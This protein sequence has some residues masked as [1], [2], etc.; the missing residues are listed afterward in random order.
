MTTVLNRKYVPGIGP[1]SGRASLMIV[2]EAPGEV[3]E[4]YGKPLIGPTGELTNDLLREAGIRRDE[5]WVTN[6]VKYRPPD[7][8]FSRL[9]EIGVSLPEQIDK[10]WEEIRTVAP[11]C[12]LAL[13]EKALGACAGKDG[14]TKYRGS[15]LA[16]QRA[17][18]PKVV[19]TFHPANLLYQ[20]KRK[21]STG[22]FKYSWKYVMIADMRRALEQSKFPELRLPDRNLRVARNSLD[23]YKFFDSYKHLDI[24]TCDIESINCVP[25]CVGFAFNKHEAISIPLF[26]KFGGIQFSDLHN[27][28]AVELW[29][30]IAVQLDRLKLIGH[31]FK[32]DDEKLFL[33]GL[34]DRAGSVYADTL[35]L[36]HT[37]NPELPSK[38]LNVISSIRTEEPFYKD[39]GG[40]FNPKK[41]DITRLLLYNA[42]DCAVTYEVWEDQD[43]ELDEVRAKHSP[44]IREFYYGYVAKLHN[45]YLEMERTG[46]KV[47]RHIRHRL[48]Q[49]YV[50]WHNRIQR[51]F[52]ERNGKGI[53]VYSYKTLYDYVYGELGCPFRKDTG[54]DTLVQLM[55]NAVNDKYRIETLSDILE[56][57]RVRKADSTYI[58]A[59]L[60]YDGRLKTSYFITG[61][62][63]G[64]STTN[65]L[66]NPIRP[67]KQAVGIS[68]QTIPKHG[69]IGPD[70]QRMLVPD[71]GYVFLSCDLSQA[72]ARIVAVL[73][74]DWELL[75]A[76]DTID[77]H[78]R[79]AALVFD[80]TPTLELGRVCS[81]IEVDKIPKNSGERFLG[82]KTR[83][84]GN[85]NMGPERHHADAHSEARRAGI[86]LDLSEY[87]AHRNLDRFH[88]ASPKIR[89]IFHRDIQYWVTKQRYLVNPYGRIRFFL[90]RLG[91]D[92][93]REAF[94]TLPQGT[95]HDTLT[96]GAMNFKEATNN[97]YR[98]L[99]EGHDS[100]DLLIPKND[101]EVAAREMKKHLEIPIDFNNCT[102]KRDIQLVIPADFEL[103]E[104]NYK[105]MVRLSL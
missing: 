47:D 68:F 105:D 28:E 29:R 10:L 3:E 74:E 92:M 71:D 31:N 40:E 97:E 51:R 41:D 99:K 14:I 69:D 66:E 70:M 98:F 77:I 7:N 53:N 82:K 21:G 94:A 6:V 18:A 26:R 11:N 62:E 22:L 5:V 44:K 35:S 60:D 32:Y 86:R 19:A 80:M 84:A 33:L 45:F 9:H 78:R 88:Q 64:R 46:F 96:L 2:A 49:K 89:G 87:K 72:E 95:V 76:F 56:D 52:N 23:V 30:I 24:A 83:H 50:A 42:K 61:T 20:K 13:G 101:V 16:S 25:V 73:C 58:N 67:A 85:Y 54:E 63:T 81:N 8:D 43:G 100:L 55:T 15:I 27:S 59:A 4:M 38:K 79:T 34:R 48:H 65:I 90:D 91:D 36:E 37:L 39:E 75:K 93:F 12:I 57:R 17:G 104:K 102:L 1:A 103:G